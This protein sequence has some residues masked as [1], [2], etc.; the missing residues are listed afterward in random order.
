MI[1]IFVKELSSITKKGKIESS[2]LALV[3]WWNPFGLTLCSKCEIEIGW[4]KPSDGARWSPWCW[5]W[6]CD[7]GDDHMKWW[8]VMMIKLWTWKRRKGKTKWAQ[9]K[10]IFKGLFYFGDQD[11]IESVITFRIDGHTIKR[12]ALIGQL[13]HLVPLGVEKLA[14]AF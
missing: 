1:H 9:G 7:D 11:T 8:D 3:N 13:D 5:R 12:G 4:S 10:G 6:T 2:T 14:F